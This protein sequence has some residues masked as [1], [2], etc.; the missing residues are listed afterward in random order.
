[1]GRKGIET[2]WA[3]G[4]K[5]SFRGNL[6]GPV[7]IL[8]FLVVSMEILLWNPCE[9]SEEKRL[10]IFFLIKQNHYLFILSNVSVPTS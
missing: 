8:I 5:I 4:P 3:K 6:V 1:M 10:C 2:I 7:R 9:L